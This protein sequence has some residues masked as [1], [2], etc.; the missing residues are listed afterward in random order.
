MRAVV[1]SQILILQLL[2]V[3]AHC[4]CHSSVLVISLSYISV[5]EWTLPDPKSQRIVVVVYIT[6]TLQHFF[7]ITHPNI[8]VDVVSSDHRVYSDND[9]TS[10]STSHTIQGACDDFT[11]Q[12]IGLLSR[13]YCWADKLMLC[14]NWASQTKPT[15]RYKFGKIVQLKL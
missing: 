15:V 5:Q 3:S 6:T 1:G 8:L 4:M 2:F 14:R 7:N 10:D 12:V 9:S 13:Y 11:D